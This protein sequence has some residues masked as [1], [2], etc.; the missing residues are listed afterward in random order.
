MNDIKIAH[1][2]IS[3]SGPDLMKPQTLINSLHLKFTDIFFVLRKQKSQRKTNSFLSITD[4]N[5]PQINKPSSENAKEGVV[6][7]ISNK[8]SNFVTKHETL[9]EG[10]ATKIQMN[11]NN[12]V[13]NIIC[14]Y[15]PSQGDSVAKPFFEKILV[16]EHFE[17]NEHNIIIGDFNAIQIPQL[18][19][20]PNPETYYKKK[21]AKIINDFKLDY[22]MVDPWRTTHP[23]KQTFS[24]KTVPMP[25]ELITP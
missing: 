17:N 22:A 24:G 11:I 5:P 2:N 1:L 7:L 23:E 14:I 13:F 10:K 4:T 9:I 8:L 21:T 12:Q 25:R 6:T 20:H 3:S 16:D 18:D 15:A 19:R